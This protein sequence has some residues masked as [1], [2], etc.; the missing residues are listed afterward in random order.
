M[1]LANSVETINVHAY[2]S[3]T[4][5]FRSTCKPKIQRVYMQSLAYAHTARLVYGI[6]SK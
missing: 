5:T 4:F 1:K 3:A 2:E 6:G